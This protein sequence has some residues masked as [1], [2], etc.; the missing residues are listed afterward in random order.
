LPRSAVAICLPGDEFRGE[1]GVGGGGLRGH[2]GRHADELETLLNIRGD[3]NL[4]ILDGE[5]DFD[6]T[7]EMYSVLH[8]GERNV[9]SLMIVSATAWSGSAWPA[10]P[11]STAS[12]SPGRIRPPRCAGA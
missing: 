4:A 12:S 2:S 1:C 6:S 8:D 10:G 5:S 9:A 11:V 3:V 7:I